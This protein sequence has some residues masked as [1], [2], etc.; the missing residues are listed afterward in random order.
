MRIRKPQGKMVWVPIAIAHA[1]A[2]LETAAQNQGKPK[3]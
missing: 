2:V 3:K 1:K